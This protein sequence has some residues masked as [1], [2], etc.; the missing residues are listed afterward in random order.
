MRALVRRGPKHAF[1]AARVAG[2][3]IST[4]VILDRLHA[5]ETVEEV[6]KDYGLTREHV[7]AAAHYE[8]G[9]LERHAGRVWREMVAD[10]EEQP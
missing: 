2:R 6:A 5:G 1:G 8:L 4:A 3:N 10:P 7:V 9:R